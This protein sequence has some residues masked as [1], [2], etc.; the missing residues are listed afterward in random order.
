MEWYYIAAIMFGSLLTLLA[1]GIPVG[2]VLMIVSLGSLYALGGGF[3]Y[4]TDLP[5]YIFH[6]LNSFTLVCVPLFITMAVF[7][8]Q[9]RFGDDLFRALNTI[10]S[11]LP[12]GV[13]NV[14][15]VACA[16]FS[17]ISG[18]SVATAAAVGLIA[19]PQFKK[20]GYEAKLSVGSLA[21]GGALGI[22]IPPSIPMIMYCV[23]CNQSIGSMFAAGL[24]PGI[25]TAIMFV[26]YIIVR[27]HINP[28]L[29]PI[30]AADST[31]TTKE[32]LRSI[33]GIAPLM[34]IIVLVLSSI[35]FG[36]CT[37][38]E[39]AAIGCFGALV[40]AFVYKRMN[41]TGIFKATV[42]A[43]RIG[44]FIILIFIG[45]IIFGHVINRGGV[46][47]GLSN[48]VLDLGLSKWAVFAVIQ[49]SLL[50]LGMFM[51]PT[52]IILTTMPVFFPLAMQVGF[53][54]IHFGVL[55][56]MNLEMACITP[57]VGF[58]LFILR[59]IG[60]GYVSMSDIIVGAAP[61]VILY[62]SAIVLVALFPNI[63]LLLP[64]LM[65]R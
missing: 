53:D 12:G 65:M 60:R 36:I 15:I 40:L 8:Q 16:I 28:K 47:T 57:P 11:R 48:L 27:C 59:G 17:A 51:D 44:A 61:F 50:I 62:M 23:I 26:T 5:G 14:A 24:I 63:A 3:T 2:F 35:Y 38:T 32:K 9:A 46:A 25:M 41:F 33:T 56:V 29:A 43:M 49:F 42:W 55:C 39:S 64:S 31:L 30:S 1:M 10:L 54:P 6:H 18:T 4:F 34:L 58:N 22:L 13:A 45:A 20:Y 21:A 52:P 37:V 19:I 7:A